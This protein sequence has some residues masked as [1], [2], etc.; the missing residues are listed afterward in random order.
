[1]QSSLLR[2][3]WINCELSVVLAGGATLT[4]QSV[5]SASEIQINALSSEWSDTERQKQRA[6][7]RLRF[8]VGCC[9]L[10]GRCGERLVGRGDSALSSLFLELGIP[11]IACPG[12]WRICF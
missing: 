3:P 4:S 10:S 9:P 8:N 11:L 2:L 7:S 5:H 1:M 6:L 12:L